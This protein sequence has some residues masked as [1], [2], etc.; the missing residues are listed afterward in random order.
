LGKY[1]K[2]A[3]V[4]AALALALATAGLVAASDRHATA[5]DT[6]VFGAAADPVTLD[7]ALA[8]DGESFRPARQIF[9]G[10][11]G[12]KPGTTQ[13]EPALATS[14]KSSNAGKTWTF[15][16]RTGVKFTDG[17]PFNAAA[18]CFNF[19]RWY[20]FKGALQNP[21]ASYYY[22]T[23]FAGFAHADS[24]DVGGP[25]EGLYKSCKANS[26]S[27]VTITLK[28][29]N[30]A[31]L[32]ATSL[33]SFAMQS[34][35]ALKQYDADKGT[36]DSNGVFHP[37]GTYGTEHPTGTGPFMF[38]SWDLGNKLV[39]VR[40]PNYW[41]PKPALST[42]IFRPI[43]DNAARLQ[44]LQ[45]G[46]IQGYDLVE[47]QDIA[48]IQKDANLKLLSRPAF[49]V[50]YVGF[51]MNSKPMDNL[52][53]R[54]AVAY[55]LD[56]QT[57]VKS[58]YSGRGVVANEFMPPLVIGYAKN[59]VKYSYNPAKAKA[60]L[61]KAGLKMPV[62]L[63][64]WYPTD[65]S[66]PYMPD[67]QRNFQAFKSSLEK[68]GFKIV[69]HSAPWRPD[70]L[71]RANAGTAGNLYLLGWTG[72]Y[73]DAD[74][75]I[76]TF[77]RTPQPQFGTSGGYGEKTMKPVFTLLNNALSEPDQDK[78]AAL[79]QQ[80]NRLIMKLLPGVPYV[81][82]SPALAFQKNVNGYVPSP[83]TDE[84]FASVTIS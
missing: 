11:T 9:E 80:A 20:N 61:K 75:F 19:N 59:V 3:L 77:F 58:F 32:G 24:K 18:V 15:Q 25:A 73:G 4:P 69:S 52:L 26:D 71:G 45:T 10:L 17:T 51:N 16:L 57:V 33:V 28:R 27:S 56:R 39:L 83:T 42:L 43:P 55:G 29:A 82:T 6:L 13:V 67:P 12:L 70:Y 23:V 35:A 54:Q 8:S 2:L 53:V 63:D 40:N 38:Q 84:S 21:S 36:V 81:H 44:A 50:A 5:S 64:F 37:G 46:E 78:R 14:W 62:K 66:R 31:F 60:L 68:S 79:Y 30:G 34:P 49:N 41:G 22:N 1:L 48:T 7:P 47:P 72:D 65:V 74:N 76:G